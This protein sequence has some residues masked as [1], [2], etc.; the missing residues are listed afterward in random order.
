MIDKIIYSEK[1]RFLMHFILRNPENRNY[2]TRM[3][4]FAV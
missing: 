1:C 3:N 2:E 4:I